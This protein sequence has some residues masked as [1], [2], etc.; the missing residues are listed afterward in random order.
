LPSRSDFDSAFGADTESCRLFAEQLEKFNR[1]FCEAMF[2]GT[3]YTITFQVRGDEHRLIQC[4]VE[5]RDWQRP[6]REK[7]KA[8]Q[9]K[10]EVRT[11][12]PLGALRNTRRVG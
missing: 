11:E 10:Q 7:K 6:Q 1:L 8:G 5:S 12:R 2:Q 3:D 4:F 9:K